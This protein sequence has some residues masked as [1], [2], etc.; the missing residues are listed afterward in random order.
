MD[1]ITLCLFSAVVGMWI[2]SGLHVAELD[3]VAMVLQIT[4]GVS[5]VVR[6]TQVGWQTSDE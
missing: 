3:S 5:A 4:V 1:K 2:T 6:W